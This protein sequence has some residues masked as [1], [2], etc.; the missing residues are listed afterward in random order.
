MRRPFDPM[1]LASGRRDS[2]RWDSRRLETGPSHCARQGWKPPLRGAG[3]RRSLG[4]LGVL[5]LTVVLGLPPGGGKAQVEAVDGPRTPE[6]STLAPVDREVFRQ[7][8]GEE[9]LFRLKLGVESGERA[10]ASRLGATGM[11]GDSWASSPQA[12]AFQAALER[13]R[14]Y[15]AGEE[16]G[17]W[18]RQ[19]GG[20]RGVNP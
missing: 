7:R 19:C 18:R 12:R 14:W 9:A 6:P 1:R 15:D 2:R 8:Y 16:L 5:G 20:G 11:C 4:W 3:P 10:P 17:M 13:K